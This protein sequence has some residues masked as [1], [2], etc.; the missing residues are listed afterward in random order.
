MLSIAKELQ[1]QAP[2]ATLLFVTTTPVPYECGS[3]S[4]CEYSPDVLI[5]SSDA[6]VI[7]QANHLNDTIV[8]KVEDPAIY[9]AAAAEA[10]SALPE[11]QTLDLYKHVTR[12]C[13]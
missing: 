2:R 3:T 7:D 6:E 5:S 10:L 12:I 13:G 4:T 1:Y 9:N 8:H 11:I